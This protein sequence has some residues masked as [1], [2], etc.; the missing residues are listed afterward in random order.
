M[1]DVLLHAG[2]PTLVEVQPQVKL[3]TQFFTV[4]MCVCVCVRV[5]TC[6]CV[7]VCVCKYSICAC[8]HMCVV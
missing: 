2:R 7:C 3:Y 8:V 1:V 5:R 6:V 4:Y